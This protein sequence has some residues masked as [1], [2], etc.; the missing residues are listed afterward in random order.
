MQSRWSVVAASTDRPIVDSSLWP[1]LLWTSLSH[2]VPAIH[3]FTHPSNPKSTSNLPTH[4]PTYLSTS[5]CNI[6][7]ATQ[8]NLL[9][10]S[11]LPNW[12]PLWNVQPAR[13]LASTCIQNYLPT[14][15]SS[16]VPQAAYLPTS[17]HRRKR[18]HRCHRHC[19]DHDHRKNWVH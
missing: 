11:N 4:L 2:I 5:Q 9:P 1:N 18:H 12:H 19:H 15:H 16:S 6:V 14:S 7:T 3:L 17:K 8:V 13:F 10:T